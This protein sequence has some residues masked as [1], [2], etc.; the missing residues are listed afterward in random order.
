MESR[1]LWLDKTVDQLRIATNPKLEYSLENHEGPANAEIKNRGFIGRVEKNRPDTFFINTQDR[2][3]T[4]TGAE[5]GEML[6]PIQEMGI[7]KRADCA[8]NYVG[9]AGAVDK[10]GN[11][12]PSSFEKSRRNVWNECDVLQ[13]T[14]MGKGPGN[15]NDNII[16]SFV[17]ASNK[18]NRSTTKQPDSIRSGFSRAVG[19]AIAPLMD[20]LRPS[21]KEELVSNMRI[22]G[23]MSSTVPATYSFNP[24]DTLK[25]TTKETTLYSP[26]FNINNQGNGHYVDTNT[27]LHTTQ[28][29]TTECGYIGPA[30]GSSTQYGDMNYDYMY[31]QHNNDIKSQTIHNRIN[32]GN[33]NLFNSNINVNIS[34]QDSDRYSTRLFTPS[35]I[36]TQPP[37]KENYGNMRKT[38]TYDE[39]MSCQRIE[40]HILDAFRANP[41]T[42]SLTNSV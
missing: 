30:G 1:D 3:L 39:G 23:D 27:P 21:K 17:N 32:T 6:R 13:S 42:H 41:Y 25:T 28:R 12:V 26:G 9:P 18:N 33:T 7:I 20:I 4:T 2:W 34:K 38:Q 19:A 8:D 22:Y 37:A 16:Q 36:F 35:S 31:R 29:E 5:K 15:N 14:A 24:N 40:P 11:Y 10:Q